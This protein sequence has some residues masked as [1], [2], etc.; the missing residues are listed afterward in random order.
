[1]VKRLTRAQAQAQT[2]ERLLEAAAQVFTRHG[3]EGASVDEVVEAA[4]LSKG[5]VYANF[6]SKEEL[7]L[8]VLD[9]CLSEQERTL[10]DIFTRET[11]LEAR[12]A[13]IG[14]WSPGLVHGQKEWR[15]LATEFWLHAARHPEIQEQ[16]AERYRIQRADIAHM[17]DQQYQELG[18]EA[19]APTEHLAAAVLALS[20]G[21]AMQKITDSEAFPDSLYATTLTL[22]LRVDK[23]RE[24]RASL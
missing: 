23:N 13:A 3:F 7:F 5:A 15:L 11:T 10:R 14:R 4:G 21:L 20:N 8:A 16:L 1:M 6:V 2:R 9:E 22:L 17:L 19:P 18:C 24:Q 12:I